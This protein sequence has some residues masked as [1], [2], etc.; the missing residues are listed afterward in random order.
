MN[1]DEI[2]DLLGLQPHREGGHY[3]ETWRDTTEE[4]DRGHGSAIYFLLRDGLESAW[5]RVDAAETWHFYAGDPV[6][7]SMGL[8]IADAVT[9]V[10]GA[11]LPAGQRPQLTVPERAWQRARSTGAWSLVGCTV[12]P[13]F[14][15][16]GFELFS[17]ADPESAD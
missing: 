17:P 1:A 13:A 6:E 3:V 9:H 8:Q 5:H 2:I 11:D 7:L 12:S 15:F 16:E 10:L 14:T 4:G